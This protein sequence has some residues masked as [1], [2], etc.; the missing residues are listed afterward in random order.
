MKDFGVVAENRARIHLRCRLEF[1]LAGRG[2][3]LGYVGYLG[4]TFLDLLVTGANQKSNQCEQ[5]GR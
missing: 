2:D 5:A 4:R 3:R 1:D